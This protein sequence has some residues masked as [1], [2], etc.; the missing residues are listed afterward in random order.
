MSASRGWRI[1]R[2]AVVARWSRRSCSTATASRS[3][4]I[5]CTRALDPPS[6]RSR[7]RSASTADGVEHRLSLRLIG[8]SDDPLIVAGELR[9]AIA[10]DRAADRV[11]GDRGR[12][13]IA[14]SA[15]P[16]SPLATWSHRGGHGTPRRRRPGD[17]PNRACG[18]R[19]VARGLRTER[20]REDPADSS[21]PGPGR[22]FGRLRVVRRR[23]RRRP[24]WPCA[25]RSS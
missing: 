2:G 8:A 14:S 23:V 25:C 16:P 1:G 6:C 20:H 10:Q 11:S 12:G 22:A 3:R 21:M 7:R 5:R 4:R 24:T 17:G 15:R 13:P 18:P 19:T 9:T